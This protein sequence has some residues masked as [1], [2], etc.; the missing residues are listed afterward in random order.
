VTHLESL[1]RSIDAA[2]RFRKRI[3][4]RRF[5]L[6]FAASALIGLGAT[7]NV[8]TWRGVPAGTSTR[9]SWQAFTQGI[10]EVVS[11]LLVLITSAAV[12]D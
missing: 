4:A 3:A 5:D 10:S 2:R 7:L 11:D 1:D 12:C 9:P 6:A 8:D